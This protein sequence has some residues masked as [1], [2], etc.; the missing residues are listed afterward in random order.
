LESEKPQLKVIYLSGYSADIAGQEV[1]LRESEAFIGK[2]FTTKHLLETI[3]R[4]L[5]A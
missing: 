1:R 5:D 2:P 4:I 3:R